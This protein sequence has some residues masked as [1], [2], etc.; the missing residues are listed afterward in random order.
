MPEFDYNVKV[1]LIGDETEGKSYLASRFC[2]NF[3]TKEYKFTIGIEFHVKTLIVNGKAMKLQIWE[4]KNEQRFKDHFSFYYRG[5]LGAIIISDISK[6]DFRYNLDENIQMINEQMGDVPIIL[7]TFN[8]QS[9][10]FQAIFGLE[11]IITAENFYNLA[12][13]E[14]SLKPT[15]D[16]EIIFKKL[17]EYIIKRCEISPPP[18]PSKRQRRS[19][20]EFI[21]NKY[22]KLRLEYSRT[23]IYVGERLF[24]QCKYLLLDIPLNQSEDYYEIESIDEA[25]EKLDHSLERGKAR[26]YQISPDIEFWGHCSNLQVW[27]EHDYDS[28]ILHSNLAFP[29]LTALVKAGDPLAKKVYKEEIALRLIS[30]YPSV[31]K[32]LINE[33]YLKYLNKEEMDSILEDSDFIRNLPKWLSDFEEIPKWLLKRI[34][35]KLNKLKCPHCDSKR[36][37]SLTKH[38]L[39]GRSIKCQYCHTDMIR[40]LNI[41]INKH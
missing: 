41:K 27:Y 21:I 17:A 10:S 19:G 16:P 38:F 22:I 23:N 26:K 32:H 8:H 31:V 28:R 11:E 2:K 1:V 13:N 30:G 35:A 9:K 33:D 39:R 14:T 6:P 12:L 3:F 18:R 29:L 25:A 37:S 7:L 5:A 34:K 15:Q 24:R 36:L 4:L 40:G 20:T